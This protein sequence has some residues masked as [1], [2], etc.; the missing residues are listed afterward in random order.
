MRGFIQNKNTVIVV[1]LVAFVS[2]LFLWHQSGSNLQD[3]PEDANNYFPQHW[4]SISQTKYGQLKEY[5]FPSVKSGEVI[6][7]Q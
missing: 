3:K 6:I 4:P 2:V 1:L 5:I 7:I